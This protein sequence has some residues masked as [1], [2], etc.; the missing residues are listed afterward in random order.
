MCQHRTFEQ[1]PLSLR[2]VARRPGLGHAGAAILLQNAAL[3][4]S[5]HEGL[6]DSEA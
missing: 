1:R 4:P 2:G 6:G 3:E 5:M